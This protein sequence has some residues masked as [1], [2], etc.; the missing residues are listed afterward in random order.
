MPWIGPAIHVCD[1]Y[2]DERRDRPIPHQPRVKVRK[3]G[4]SVG[5]RDVF[6]VFCP[7]RVC[8]DALPEL[9]MP[10]V[11]RAP[12]RAFRPRHPDPPTTAATQRR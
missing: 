9:W 11:E 5:D 12:R 8:G 3:P 6:L 2:M 4:W 10:S 1:A 7:D